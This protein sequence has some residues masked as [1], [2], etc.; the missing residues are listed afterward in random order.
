MTHNPLV[1]AYLERELVRLQRI[2]LRRLARDLRE[3]QALLEPLQKEVAARR[4]ANMRQD[5]PHGFQM[6]ES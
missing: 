5:G 6:V 2:E 4:K 1:L 3:Q